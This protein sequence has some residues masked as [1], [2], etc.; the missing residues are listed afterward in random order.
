[1]PIGTDTLDLCVALSIRVP[2]EWLGTYLRW[3]GVYT[4]GDGLGVIG[5][6]Q[7]EGGSALPFSCCG[8]V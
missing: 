3:W 1:M 7:G 4:Q 8:S 6:S 5:G 2:P